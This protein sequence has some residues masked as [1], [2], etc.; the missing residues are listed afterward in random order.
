MRMSFSSTRKEISATPKAKKTTSAKP[1]VR[2]LPGTNLGDLYRDLRDAG[3]GD[4]PGGEYGL[5]RERRGPFYGRAGLSG[6]MSV[7]ATWPS[8]FPSIISINAWAVRSGMGRTGETYLVGPDFRLRSDTFNDPEARNIK[9]SFEGTVKDKRSGY[10]GSPKG[11]GGKG[12]QWTAVTDYRGVK[13]FSAYAPV[14]IKD[15]RWVIVSENG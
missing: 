1:D 8:A 11:P 3:D 7:W 9:A 14:P 12:G 4:V 6:K 10:S 15:L 5:V 2:N 13:V